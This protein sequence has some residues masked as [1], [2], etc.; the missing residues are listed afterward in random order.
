MAADGPQLS[1]HL[2]AYTGQTL[3]ILLVFLM[4]KTKILN[5]QF[6]MLSFRGEVCPLEPLVL[7]SSVPIH[8]C[9]VSITVLKDI[10]RRQN[11]A[12]PAGLSISATWYDSLPFGFKTPL[13]LTNAIPNLLR[14]RD[15]FTCP[16]ESTYL[17]YCLRIFLLRSPSQPWRKHQR[18][19]APPTSTTDWLSKL[20]LV[21]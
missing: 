8:P 19:V 1:S 9:D 10:Y 16:D 14:G 21:L 20:G 12:N 17:A 13:E 2:S 3:L 4:N 15:R 18:Q 7:P 11:L 6:L 5:S